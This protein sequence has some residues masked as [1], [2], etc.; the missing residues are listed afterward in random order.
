MAQNDQVRYR[1]HGSDQ[2]ESREFLITQQ[3][4]RTIALAHE[5]EI[6]TIA[7]KN[8]SDLEERIG[9]KIGTEHFVEFDP[10]EGRVYK[11]THPGTFGL[12]PALQK[13]PL[14]AGQF[15]RRLEILEATPLEY[16]LRW[17]NNNEVFEDQARLEGIIQWPDDKISIA[18]S[19]P[20]YHGVPA[21]PSE[22]ESHF[23]A[24]GWTLLPR[25]SGHQLFF[26]YAFN[27]LAIDAEPRNVYLT[28]NGLQPFDV[29]LTEP[30]PELE[31][32]LELYPS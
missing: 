29:I 24:A 15:E 7:E 10:L 26:N 18:I 27:V 28:E 4:Q 19:Q 31:D 14:P 32:F 6:L 30:S 13:V 9:I 20:V 23:L 17:L 22:I 11:T 2:R 3:T 5:A 12:I 16:L 8:Y 1:R 25:Q 21:L